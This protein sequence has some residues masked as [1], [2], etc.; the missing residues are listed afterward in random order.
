VKIAAYVPVKLNSER[1][2]NK[3]ILPFDNGKPLI[4]YILD[5]LVRSPGLDS[6]HV[7]CSNP[8][9]RQHL[10]EHVQ[11]MSRSAN[12]DLSTAKINEVMRAFADDVYAD[13]Y[14]LAHATSPFLSPQTI[15]LGIEKVR[16]GQYDSALTVA[17]LRGFLWFDG[18]PLNYDPASIAR[19][20]D[21]DPFFCE[22]TG[23]YIYPRELLIEHNRRVGDNPYLIEVS[24]IEAIDIND[25]VDF[26]IA[27][28]IFNHLVREDDGRYSFESSSYEHV[29]DQEALLQSHREN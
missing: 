27:N 7:Y 13:V 18:K 20:Q 26:L 28:A 24:A 12:L 17:P 29:E 10:P 11:Y 23:L 8:S 6:I 5:A 16:S 21:L 3:N 14:V 19:T 1:L 15:E 4:T 22:T 9:V 25:P 2:P